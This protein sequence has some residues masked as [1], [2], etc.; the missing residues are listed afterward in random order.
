M[1]QITDHPRKTAIDGCERGGW[2]W[3]VIVAGMVIV[4]EGLVLTNIIIKKI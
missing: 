2:G 3:M 1:I 4:A